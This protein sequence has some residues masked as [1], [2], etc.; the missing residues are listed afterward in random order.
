MHLLICGIRINLT[1]RWESDIETASISKQ[2]KKSDE[3]IQGRCLE[4]AWK[5]EIE[6]RIRMNMKG[7]D[8]V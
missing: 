4:L 2:K 8:R 5:H 3:F 6:C 1:L 7:R